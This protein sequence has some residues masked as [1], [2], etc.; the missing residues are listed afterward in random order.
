MANPLFDGTLPVDFVVSPTQFN[1]INHT[2]PLSTSSTGGTVT[3]PGTITPPLVNTTQQTALYKMPVITGSPA[4]LPVPYT[5]LNIVALFPAD[6]LFNPDGGGGGG[7]GGG[8]GTGGG[9]ATG[10]GGT[11][12]TSTP[13]GGI[14]GN[15][16][17]IPMFRQFTNRAIIALG[18]GFP[19]Q[20]FSDPLT[21]VNPATT[22]AIVSVTPDA[23]GV[24]TVVTATP[25]GL[26]A[27]QVG[28]NVVIS[29][30]ANTAYNFAG[31]TIQIVNSTTYKVMNFGTGGGAPSSGG[32]SV[33]TA[34]PIINTFVPAY[35]VWAA[36]ENLIAG[37]VIVPLTQPSAAIYLVVTQG[38]QTGTVEPT[39]PTG[40]SASV[41]Q[42]VRDG[43]VIYQVAGLLNSAAPA[44]PGAAHI[45]V[46]SGAL[47]VLNTAPS[48]TASGLDGPC[49]IRMSS[50][51]QP[52]SWNPINQA[53]LDKDDGQ[54]GMGLAKFTI[55]AQGIPPEG[56]LIAF[57]NYSPYQ[58][59]GVFGANNFAIQAVS[60]DMGCTAPRTLQFVPGF[61]IMRYTHLGVAI[62]NGVKDEII[63]EQIRCRGGNH[64]RALSVGRCCAGWTMP[65]DS[66][67]R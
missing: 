13:S 38:G 7:S 52:N 19:P 15:V 5:G 66:E 57:K 28:G 21:L 6:I 49:A 14:P 53:F 23:F 60:S 34:L 50:I 58:I 47:W 51:N 18:N 20:I 46:Y 8:G 32:T 63:S 26:L 44:P 24:M 16:S 54:E 42:T 39:W 4:P 37:D 17:F 65:H 40:G 59:V 45:E 41:G 62:F 33:T 31:P 12:S 43:T 22:A 61:G 55:T 1:V 29:G 56:S 25:H 36:T 30:V 10:G 2:A 3:I 11:G 64:T 35:P 67:T 48:N 27:S 9:G